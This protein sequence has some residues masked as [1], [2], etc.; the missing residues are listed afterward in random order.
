MKVS[1][2]VLTLVAASPPMSMPTHR[3]NGPMSFNPIAASA[4]GMENRCRYRHHALVYSLRVMSSPSS[5][6]RTA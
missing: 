3:Q 6:T 2:L 5:P 1:P 4:Y